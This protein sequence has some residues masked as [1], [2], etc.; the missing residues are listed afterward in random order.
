MIDRWK[1]LFLPFDPLYERFKSLVGEYLTGKYPEKKGKALIAA[2]EEELP[3][4]TN[5]EVKTIFESEL[6]NIRKAQAML[7]QLEKFGM[8]TSKPFKAAQKGQ[9][10]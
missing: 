6:E 5:P 1:N 7:E 10:A 4:I 2:M 8:D 9:V 3:I